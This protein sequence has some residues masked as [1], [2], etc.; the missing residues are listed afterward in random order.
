[1]QSFEYSHE[2]ENSAKKNVVNR[3]NQ[4]VIAQN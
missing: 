4:E 2:M 3:R 1:M